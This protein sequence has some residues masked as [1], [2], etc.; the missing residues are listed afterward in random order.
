MMLRN[1]FRVFGANFSLV[2]K[3][4]AYKM[5]I[6]LIFS[7]II[8]AFG[9]KLIETLESAGF[10]S[11]FSQFW[12]S[13]ASLS[14]L[15]FSKGIVSLLNDFFDIVIAN[16]S[17]LSINLIGIVLSFFLMIV[18]I[19]MAE[20]PMAEV[21]K[22]HMSSLSKFSFCGAFLSN[23]W[24]ATKQALVLF[25]IKLPFWAIIMVSGFYILNLMT[26]SSLWAILS[27]M[28]FVLLVAV[29]FSIK[30]TIFACFTPYLCLHDCGI[31]HALK[32]GVQIVSRRFYRT[33]S[34]NIM[35][36]VLAFVLNF[37]CAQYTFGVA[38]L[39]TLPSTI[40]F[41]NVFNM[42]VYYE[43]QGMR[44]YIDPMTIMRTKDFS[45]QDSAKKARNVI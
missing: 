27:P 42:V 5:L 39:L 23:F 22:W 30:N 37:V 19:N 33:W 1:A 12:G 31:F 4:L 14:T 44:Y 16:F 35:F 2:W 43:S 32:K 20:L 15:E 26:V 17:G 24:R 13:T 10:F 40:V 38:L 36:V 45:E 21:I 11:A 34:N 18:F 8:V 7:G 41:H 9:M 29:V 6:I 28:L 25:V 3:N